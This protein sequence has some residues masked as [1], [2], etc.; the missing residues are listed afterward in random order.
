MFKGMKCGQ[1]IFLSVDGVHFRIYKEKP[2]NKH[3]YSHKFKK[4]GLTYEIASNIRTGDNCWAFG[5]FPAGCN[6]LAMSLKGLSRHLPVGEKVIADKG[7]R[8]HPERY[9][10]PY[11]RSNHRIAMYLKNYG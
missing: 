1:K 10:T 4:A 2:F 9:L 8:G 6:D 7:Y 11:A 3:L 5:G